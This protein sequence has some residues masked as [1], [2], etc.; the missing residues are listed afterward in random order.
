MN[1]ERTLPHSQTE[2]AHTG[3]TEYRVL[4]VVDESLPLVS[5][6][7]VRT[8]GIVSAELALGHLPTVVTSLNHQVRQIGAEDAVINGV[9]YFRT[10]LDAGLAARILQGHVPIAR[11]VLIVNSL[12]RRVL[13]A[14]DSGSFN[15]IHAHSPALCGLAALQAA[16]RRKLPLVYEVRAFWEDAAVDQGKTTPQ[17]VRYRV[18]RALEQFVVSRADAVVGI[19]SS[20]LTELR[21]RGVDSSKLFHVPNGVDVQKFEP[22]P[23]NQQLAAKLGLVDVP[24][25]GFIGSLFTFEGISWLV[26]AAVELHH[27]GVQFKLVI[28]GHGE[29]EEQIRKE[30]AAAGA[31]SYI[32]FLGKVPHDEIRDY[33]SLIDVLVYP[34]RSIRL[35]ELVTPLKPLEAMALGRTV[36][37]SSVGG[38]RE[39]VE[40]GVTGLLFAPEDIEDFCAKAMMLLSNPDLRARLAHQAR[41][42]IL[43]EKQ[44]V[45]IA[46]RYQQ[47]YDFAGR[48]LQARTA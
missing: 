17:S 12:R 4:H 34:R 22:M 36:M 20:I 5:G 15:V 38:I 35:T 11:E 47:V 8:S 31:E 42:K 27:R 45:K 37:G 19:A 14:L 9:S 29:E 28:I 16:R 33:Y 26:R 30:I 25:L 18:S 40:D 1:S 6:Y 48:S 24:I 2:Q 32:L 23:S 10:R 43:K 13:Q 46:A 3:S 21:S 41:E 39:L 7:A 44:W